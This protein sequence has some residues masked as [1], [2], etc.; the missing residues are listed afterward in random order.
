MGKTSARVNPAEGN[1]EL[2]F[3][4]LEAT[5]QE[6]NREFEFLKDSWRLTQRLLSLAETASSV[7]FIQLTVVPVDVTHTRMS[8]VCHRAYVH[9]HVYVGCQ[10]AGCPPNA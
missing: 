4:I 3:G 5:K 8:S 6:V 2:L 9:M 10:R 1:W 7:Q